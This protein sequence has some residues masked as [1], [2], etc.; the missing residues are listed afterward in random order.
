MSTLMETR[1]GRYEILGELGR[2]SMGIVYKARD[3][4]LDRLVALKT[5]RTERGLRPEHQA[6]GQKRLYQEATAVAR[7]THPNIVAVYD[8]IP[9]EDPCLVMEYVEGHTLAELVAQGPLDPAR[10]THFVLQVCEALDYAHRLGVVHR[11]IKSANILVTEKGVA[12]LTD[13]SIAR[14]S[15]RHATQAG[16]MM[17]TPAYIAPEQFRGHA[18]EP[19]SDL[20]SLGVVLYELVTGVLPFAGEDV[21][22]VLYRVVHVD[23]M[24]PRARNRDVSPALDAVIRRAMSKE[25]AER[26]SSARACAEA[27]ADATNP[28]RP[29]AWAARLQFPHPGTAWR[30]ATVIGAACL[31]MGGTVA[32]GSESRRPAKIVEAVSTVPTVSTPQVQVA[33]DGITIRH[34]ENARSPGIDTPRRELGSS[35]NPR[36]WGR[37]RAGTGPRAPETTSA[38]APSDSGQ[39]VQPPRSQEPESTAAG[40]ATGCLSVNA[41][42]FASVYVDG[43]LFGETPRAC[44]RVRVGQRRV[45]FQ[46][47]DDQSPERVVQITEHHTAETPQ[48]LSYDFRARQFRG[49]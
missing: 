27:L 10:A 5:V 21:A 1:I 43:R 34:V 45:H 44:F 17:G 19:R 6:E 18:A 33:S 15:G 28:R 39:T 8:V 16:A 26:Y 12:K 29:F 42:P 47:S 46:A 49:P 3:P 14:L 22:A 35:P 4:Q 32:G 36:L 9:G 48:K 23:P 37:T 13:F 31:I 40:N 20:F 38:V 41:T 30:H 7:L 24:P 11:D 2:G 25:P